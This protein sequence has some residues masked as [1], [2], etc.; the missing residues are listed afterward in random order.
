[1]N[2]DPAVPTRGLDRRKYLSHVLVILSGNGAAQLANLLGYP[3]LARLYSPQEF[4]LFGMFVAVAAV[5]GTVACGRFEFAIPTA[6]K[7][8]ASSLLWLCIAISLGLGLISAAAAVIYFSLGAPGLP[9]AL[10]L[11][12]GLCVSL[13]GI[14]AAH[15]IFLLRHEYYRA[16]STSLV[17]RT[18]TA[19]AAQIGLA[20]LAASALS[21]ILGFVLGLAV[22]AAMLWAVTWRNIRPRPPRARNMMAMFR[23][24]RRQV[25]VDFPSTLIAA[26][27]A[28]IL[29]FALAIR[30]DQKTVGF[31][32]MGSR[33]AVVPLTLFNDSLSQVFFQKAARARQ[34]KGHIWDELKFSIAIS[35][36]VSVGI[37]L[38]ILVFARPAIAVFLGKEWMPAA[39]MLIVLAP[40]LAV[41]SLTMSVATT[42]FLLRSAHWLFAHNVATVAV[43]LA[44]FAATILLDLSAIGFLA[45]ASA[46][47][48]IEYA[49]FG[50][51]LAFAARREQG[52]KGAQ[53]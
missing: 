23:Q 38:G 20:L 44:A 43:P 11:L 32:S 21:L 16:A 51:F 42:V 18:G 27:A 33:L 53:A 50:A 3:I 8:G 25:F 19:V 45:V 48:C 9:I 31:Y 34:D 26:V 12:F 40:M 30:F 35:A 13:T 41:R 24:F 4:G 39:D 49:V 14:C 37:L 2:L 47:L 46:G 1:L 36:L 28:N 52:L 15:S 6:P 22:Q 7:W 17:I 10:P 29:T 5:P